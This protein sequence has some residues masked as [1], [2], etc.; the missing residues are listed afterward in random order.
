[1]F[2]ADKPS[3]LVSRLFPFVSE[4][5][6]KQPLQIYYLDSTH[7]HQQFLGTNKKLSLAKYSSQT[8][9]KETREH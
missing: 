7:H 2:K 8:W 5:L 3:K 1:M 9:Q 6:K 4:I